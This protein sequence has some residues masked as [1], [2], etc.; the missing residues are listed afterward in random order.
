MLSPNAQSTFHQAPR[1]GTRYSAM[2]QKLVHRALQGNA[3][4]ILRKKWSLSRGENLG[5][6]K[7]PSFVTSLAIWRCANTAMT[8]EPAL[9]LPFKPS[10]SP[11]LPI[12]P[13]PAVQLIRSIPTIQKTRVN[14]RSCALVVEGVRLELP[15]IQA[16][17]T[18]C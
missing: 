5:E 16:S 1:V 11:G 12:R 2:N 3:T 4:L 14:L 9:T 15:V 7:V 18:D 10:L 17:S 13:S 6:A 8:W